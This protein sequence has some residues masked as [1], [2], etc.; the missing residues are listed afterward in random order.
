MI[1]CFD[2]GNTDIDVGVFE[3]DMHIKD[4]HIP[5]QKEYEP[6]PIRIPSLRR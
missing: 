2:I 4:F 6:Y 1:L 3:N 5:Y